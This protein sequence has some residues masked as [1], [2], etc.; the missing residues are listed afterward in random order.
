M[1]RSKKQ[2]R[3]RIYEMGNSEREITQNEQHTA[4][5]TAAVMINKTKWRWQQ[6]ERVIETETTIIMTTTITAAAAAAN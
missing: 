6:A 3:E 5:H 1:R 2:R 4:R